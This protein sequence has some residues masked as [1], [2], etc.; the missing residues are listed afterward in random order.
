LI[1][2][3]IVDSNVVTS[4]KPSESPRADY[5]FMV[6]LT[7]SFSSESSKFLTM[8]QLTN[9]FSFTDCLKFIPEFSLPLAG[10]NMC[11]P[12]HPISLFPIIRSY[13]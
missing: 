4:S 5:D 8:I 6:I 13:A 9:V 2:N 10:F 12:R 3:E 7:E 1:K 11:H